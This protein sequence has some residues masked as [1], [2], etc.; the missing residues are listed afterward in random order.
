MSQDE[1]YIRNK[2]DKI[3][4]YSYVPDFLGMV[5]HLDAVSQIILSKAMSL[6]FYTGDYLSL[7][8]L[9]GVKSLNTI[10]SKVKELEKK[11]YIIKKTFFV[12]G[13][14]MRTIIVSCYDSKWNKRSRDELIKLMSKAIN[15]IGEYY[16][17]KPLYKKPRK[18]LEEKDI[19]NRKGMI[20]I[21]DF[22]L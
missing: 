20:E 14:K 13:T 4:G 18:K 7:K 22:D 21:A 17:C 1:Q 6:G 19:S 8:E 3:T 12:E 9:T 15:A 16:N 5:L 2:I 11:G 10:V